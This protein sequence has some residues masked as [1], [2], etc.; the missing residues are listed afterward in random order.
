MSLTGIAFLLVFF[1]GLFLAFVRHPSYGLYTYI[2]V[3]YLHP[4]SRWWGES[5]PDLRWALLA[6]IVTLIASWRLPAIP[7][8]RPWIGSVPGALLLLFT[9]WLWIQS[10]WALDKEEHLEASFLFTKYVLLFYLIFRLV[11]TPADVKKFLIVHFLGCVFLGWLALGETVSGRLEGVGGP[12]IDE[13]NAFAMQL[14]TGVLA[15]AMLSLAYADWRRWAIVV[16][17]PLVLNGVIL[18]GSRG[19]FLALL[20][21]GLVLWFM[22]P[23]EY[24]KIFYV[25]AALGV[26]LFGMLAHDAFWERMETI[27]AI[28]RPGEREMDTSAESRIA[29][30]KAQ[31]RMAA[32]YPQGTGHRGTSVLSPL[33]IEEKYLAGR[34]DGAQRRRSSHSTFMT[35]LAEQGVPGAVWF[36]AIWVWSARA[37]RSLAR[38]TRQTADSELRMLTAVVAAALASVFIAGMFVDYMKAEVQVWFWALLASLASYSVG[39]SSGARTHSRRPNPSP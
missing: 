8:R 16:M 39:Y 35:A 10:L 11:V 38:H 6:A 27:G 30:A 26:L 25:F 21:G 7:G 9:A 14:S 19:G 1:A 18:S 23:V 2:A 5:L 29:I 28:T 20:V 17:I 36:I 13:A 3:F 22:K 34:L 33:Y 15:G 31:L 4:P 32:D 24:R 12:G 37:A